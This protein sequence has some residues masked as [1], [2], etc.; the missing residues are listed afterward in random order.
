MSHGWPTSLHVPLFASVGSG[1]ALAP[2]VAQRISEGI[3]M[4]LMADGEQLPPES[5]LAAQLDI[6]TVSLR[7]ALAILRKDGLIETRRGRNGGSFIRASGVYSSA[8]ATERLAH[9]SPSQLRDLGDEL[10]AVAG[11]VA[12]LA[13]RR[14]DDDNVARL[15][16]LAAQLAAAGSPDQCLRLDSRLWIELA[17]AGQSERLTRRMVS[18]QAEYS[19]L[20]WLP[21]VGTDIAA[22]AASLGELIGAIRTGAA[23]AARAL[24]EALVSQN[25]RR[26][27]EHRLGDRT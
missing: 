10:M 19:D 20:L 23:D 17:V 8:K 14:F 22:C 26:I 11:V 12:S 21:A 24:A 15:D 7:A 16:D 27:V 1:G 5:E 3:A 13:A 9:M 18:L 25:T 4:G 6:S 2:A